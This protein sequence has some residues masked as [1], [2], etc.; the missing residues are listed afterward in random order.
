VEPNSENLP[1]GVPE[2]W[3][4][5]PKEPK[6]PAAPLEKA[7]KKRKPRIP[8]KP[9][10]FVE[11]CDFCTC[12]WPTTVPF[13]DVIMKGEKKK[14]RVCNFCNE[15]WHSAPGQMHPSTIMKETFAQQAK[16]K[17]DKL[18]A[19]KAGKDQSPAK[20]P[21]PPPPLEPPNTQV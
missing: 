21:S 3:V 15:A 8:D 14:K 4:D 7:K 9:P 5:K 17:A 2:G 19:E 1:E 20:E 12:Y 6:D 11:G 16:E 10:V 13:F 18:A